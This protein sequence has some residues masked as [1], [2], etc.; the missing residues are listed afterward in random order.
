MSE[1]GTVVGVGRWRR[2]VAL[3]MMLLAAFVVLGL[4]ER[5][6]A[7]PGN[8]WVI[9]LKRISAAEQL[10]G[11][12]VTFRLSL[13]CA[14]LTSSSC[15]GGQVAIPLPEGR[16]T[17]SVGAHPYISGYSVSNNVLTI[18]LISSFPA[19]ASIQTDIS[20][21]LVN[22]YTPDGT[23]LSLQA[24]V[25][26]D[27]TQTVTSG[28]ASATIR[29]SANLTVH[30]SLPANSADGAPMPRDYDL[31][32]RLGPCTSVGSTGALYMQ[33]GMT[34]VDQLPAG[35]VFVD[36]S[37]GG[38]YDAT[39][40]TVTWTTDGGLPTCGYR[41][42][43][44]GPYWVTVKYPSATFAAGQS[45]TNTA[46]ATGTPI[47]ETTPLTATYSRNHT[48][49][50]PGNSGSFCKRAITPLMTGSIL[51]GTCNTSTAMATWAGDWAET[52]EPLAFP[53]FSF[54][55]T[56]GHP[57]GS[58]EGSFL[59]SITNTS[60]LPAVGEIVDPVPCLDNYDA[61]QNMYLP[62]APGVL[63]QHPAYHIWA[64]GRTYL[65]GTG[66]S[67]EYYYVTPDGT[68]KEFLPPETAGGY[69]HVL[70]ADGDVVAE[71]RI[72]NIALDASSSTATFDVW[73]HLDGSL[74]NGQRIHNVGYFTRTVEG[75]STPVVT[76]TQIGRMV[77]TDQVRV[78][79]YKSATY[80]ASGSSFTLRA[81]VMGP[82]M[83]GG[84]SGPVT[85][86]DLLPAGIPSATLTSFVYRPYGSEWPRNVVVA[87]VSSPEDT[88]VPESAYTLEQIPN[89]NGS[90][91]TLIRIS[92]PA[93]AL[94]L[95]STSPTSLWA[96][97]SVPGGWPPGTTVNN[98]QVVLPGT[99]IDACSAVNYHS[100]TGGSLGL[101]PAGPGA[102]PTTPN[103]A[104]PEHVAAGAPFCGASA[105]VTNATPGPLLQAF[106]GVKGSGDAEFAEF[107]AVGMIDPDNPGSAEY[108]VRVRSGG[109]VALKDVVLYDVLPT[110]GDMG[111]SGAMSA[112]ARGSD[113]RPELT[114]GVTV[115][116]TA[117]GSASRTWQVAYSTS[118]NP[119]RDEVRGLADDAPWPASCDDDWSTTLPADPS[120]VT[121]LRFKLTAGSLAAGQEAAFTWP[122]AEPDPLPAAGEVAWNSVAVAANR[123]DDSTALLP[124]EP[125]KVG[126]AVPQADV[127]VAK[128]VDRETAMAGQ[129]VTFTVK[130]SHDTKVVTDP[131]T[132][133][134]S[135][136][137]ENGDPTSAVAP[138][139]GLKLTDVLPAGFTLV[140]GSA[141]V[142]QGSFDAGTGVWTV[143]DLP[144]GATRTLTYRAV[145][146]AAGGHT[147]TAQVSG[148]D[149][150]DL[151]STPGNCAEDDG[152]DDCATA[153]VRLVEPSLSLTKLVETEAGSDDYVDEAEYE[154]GA[155]VRY[156]YVVRNDGEVPLTNVTLDD[157]SV[158]FFCDE[159]SLFDLDTLDPGE[160]VTVECAWPLGW[161]EGTHDYT[162]TVSGTTPVGTTLAAAD[163]AVVVVTP[164][165]TAPAVG[166]EVTTNG[167]DFDDDL[168]PGDPVTWTYVVTNTGDE[169]L[170]EVTLSDDRNPAVTLSED[171][172]TRSDGD[173]WGQPLPAGESITCEF[174]GTADEDTY[175]NTASA[176]GVGVASDTDVADDDVTGYSTVDPAPSVSVTATTDGVEFASGLTAGEEVVWEYVVRNTGNEPLTDVTLADDRNPAVA[177]TEDAC[178]RSDG[179][180][181]GDPLTP[182]ETIT[183]SFTGSA[184]DGVYLNT[185]TT[186]GTGTVSTETA[187][188]TDWTGHSV[189]ATNGPA[190]RVGIEVTTNGVEF[191]ADLT[192]GGPVT[193]EYVVTN[194]GGE[195]LIDL[196][197]VDDVNGT[198][199]LDESACVRS[200]GAAW[201]QPL[202]VAATITCTFTGTADDALRLNIGSVD[203][204]GVSSGQAVSA[205]D[206]TGYSTETADV[207]GVS[208]TATT[209]GEDFA[210]GLA[211]G[212]P[213]TWTYVVT[214]TSD[215]ALSDL[216]LSDD[217][218][219]DVEL[220]E[221]ACT[222]SDGGDW[223]DPLPAG[224]SI[225]CEFEGEAVEGSYVNTASATG[226]GETSG[227]TVD[228]TDPTGYVALAP[229]P[230][231]GVSVSVTTN[232][233]EFAE[234][235]TA[236]E[237]VVWEYVLT[238][239]GEQP[240]ESLTLADD[241]NPA[242]ALSEDACVRSDGA[243]WGAA[244]PVGE[245]ITCTFTGTASDGS[246][247]VYLNTATA[248]GT[249]TVSG[250]SAEADDWTGYSVAEPDD[251][252]PG[253]TVE[254]TTNGV[255]FAEDLT[256]GSTVTWE[257]VLTNTGDEPLVDLTLGD[258]VNG[259]VALDESACVRSDGAAW[260]APLPV[261]ATI[262]CTFTGTAEDALRLN[263]ATANGVGASSGQAVSAE[264]WTGYSTVVASTPG[265]SVTATTNGEEVATGLKPGDPVTWTY[266]VTNTGDEAL[267][268]L[269]LSDDRNPDVELREDACTRSDGAAWGSPLPPGESIT[270]EFE[271]TAVEG[272]YVNTA[273]ATGVG[274]TSG[275][276]V[277]GTD[278]TGYVAL[279]PP[280]PTAGIS[281]S[282]TTNGLEFA[283]G[284]V[285]GSRV[286]WKYVVTNTGEQPLENLTLSDDRNPAVALTED[287][288]ERSDGAEWGSPLPPGETITCEF[289]GTAVD[290]LY[291]NSAHAT[292]VGT[293]T[294]TPVEATDATGHEGSAATDPDS[295]TPTDPDSE[296]PGADTPAASSSGE[297]DDDGL[298][299]ST[300]VLVNAALLAAALASVLLGALIS[301]RERVSGRSD[302]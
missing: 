252:V 209:N 101:N 225:T 58:Y 210:A 9:Q 234:D 166:V 93:G 180:T 118:D 35:A 162:G 14:A 125:P 185:A 292:G 51:N 74:T 111:V 278:P 95:A 104:N 189:A 202:P 143:G 86:T 134:A 280:A 178:V 109:T 150:E 12:P 233:V 113:F 222:R 168:A 26:A 174:D 261:D 298:L 152:E 116:D 272:A 247:G 191:A 61:T 236:G 203:A 64:V 38:V 99:D 135:Y 87:G 217:R 60:V 89:W 183:C 5:S 83:E 171:A 163:N 159:T 108:R 25:G 78:N 281:V 82:N 112:N 156:R 71:V 167:V 257:Y 227:N 42:Q 215:E 238:N 28:V 286:V 221:D 290:G 259:T 40:N 246:D 67:A 291:A 75:A 212:D 76:G 204:E 105:S 15:D 195:P 145:M 277:D 229:L 154:S 283:S 32:Y 179:G 276:T 158:P 110:P 262:T 182:G 84:Y 184:S 190:P 2:P 23:V 37:S 187:T 6:N 295:E 107:P 46:I 149:V 244:L 106:K 208:V 142:T 18:D 96:T 220:T 264:D 94:H 44:A 270:C 31:T 117:T 22:G 10:S 63:C 56:S 256:P 157:P 232:G 213:V 288:C 226:V 91:R 197:L 17:T 211:P 243:A 43:P 258:D 230:A 30:K 245:S 1:S 260:G 68:E 266:V 59:L 39:T 263:T 170:T 207:P 173:A 140:P 287:A 73:G 72:R 136:V 165:T 92:I 21:G 66:P 239:T 192:S 100:W 249:G 50:A 120:A 132:G 54:P 122:V 3:A 218:N 285:T 274:E 141:V 126:L 214:N 147:N 296:T 45:V 102:A 137:D 130:A 188:A 144:V 224:E 201:G 186:Q 237:E 248:Q 81:G 55:S 69:A 205:E 299:P 20:T 241:R 129:E 48:F 240:L 53:T 7:E 98:M 80:S 49:G 200:D 133:A 161:P 85:I 199:A 19:G 271:G 114:G 88:P 160:E 34:V 231:A 24:T 228:D 300:G 193:W 175:F 198:V 16:M 131:V 119:C 253:L 151:D 265:V 139:Y 153:S 33:P 255:E 123:A 79:A 223:G 103:T 268:G 275:N 164:F 115:T 293:V 11:A 250:E 289:E 36:A 267:T 29:A 235:L 124:S 301:R 172:C 97:F 4:S 219:P 196:A 13:Q 194:T 8:T 57:R 138:A 90:G 282:V 302:E 27:N 146:N 284:L 254:V 176:T 62:N 294:G 273:T 128:S 121:A 251:S 269:T 169:A 77:A 127:S 181:W 216:T 155:P 65:S 177:L 242:V 206:W 297:A 41:S 279:A 70:V 148:M 52:M 47:G